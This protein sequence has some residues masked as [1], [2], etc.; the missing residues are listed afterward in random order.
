MSSLG[1]HV[2]MAEGAPEA[3]I[4]EPGTDAVPV[5]D[6]LGLPSRGSSLPARG[7]CSRRLR[8]D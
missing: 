1:V 5:Q 8:V 2:E 4:T 7:G 3:A 6:E